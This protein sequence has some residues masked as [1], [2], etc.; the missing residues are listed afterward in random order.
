MAWRRIE[1]WT[2]THYMYM[3]HLPM[4]IDPRFG[5]SEDS[6]QLAGRMTIVRGLYANKSRNQ[7]T[8]AIFSLKEKPDIIVLPFR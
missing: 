3:H 8:T 7:A 2:E 5:E 6:A 1:R 4:L